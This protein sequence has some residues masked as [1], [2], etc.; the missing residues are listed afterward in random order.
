MLKSALFLAAALPLVAAP[1]SQADRE[2]LIRDLNHSRQ[3]FLDAIADVKSEAQWNY[4]LPTAG[5]W[6]SA[7]PTS[8]LPNSTFVTISVRH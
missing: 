2:K 4:P 8:S 5:L 7:R 1:I 6:L 3:M